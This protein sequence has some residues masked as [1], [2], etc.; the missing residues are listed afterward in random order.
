MRRAHRSTERSTLREERRRRPRRGEQRPQGAANHPTHPA[1]ARSPPEGT[2]GPFLFPEGGVEA[3]PPFDR[4]KHRFVRNAEGGPEG[5][6]SA[7]KALR[8]IPP[9]Q[10]P[11][12]RSRGHPGRFCGFNCRFP[13]SCPS[14]GGRGDQMDAS[15]PLC[16]VCEAACPS[17]YSR[18][19]LHVSPSPCIAGPGTHGCRGRRPHQASHISPTRGLGKSAPSGSGQ[20]LV[21]AGFTV[22]AARDSLVIQK[23]VCRSGTSRTTAGDEDD[24][25]TGS[26]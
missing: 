22:I 23:A 12:A 19:F 20:P 6:S 2:R 17:I 13:S 26:R 1:S 10:Q 9:M 4:A 5:V 11:P 24:K 25:S 16:C 14:P 7:H 8:I 15:V 3:N 21:L 18:T